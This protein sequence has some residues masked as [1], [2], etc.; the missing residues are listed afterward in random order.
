MFSVTLWLPIQPA[1]LWLRR[2]PVLSALTSG[3][4]SGGCGC[5]RQTQGSRNT[6][7]PP[8]PRPEFIQSLPGRSRTG[9]PARL[10]PQPA[11][12]SHLLRAWP[13]TSPR[14]LCAFLCR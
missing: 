10:I 4:E 12:E 14:A 7:A 9:P 3:G 1:D 11:F 5:Q 6:P 13:G 2:E 8:A